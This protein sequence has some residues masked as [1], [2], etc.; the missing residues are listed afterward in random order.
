M[1]EETPVDIQAHI[2]A[3]Q[4]QISQLQ[5]IVAAGIPSP[6]PSPKGLKVATPD[7]YSG[8]LDKAETFLRQL[9]LYMHAKPGDFTTDDSRILFALSYMK[10]GT[11]GPWADRILEQLE[12]GDSLGD[13]EGFREH[14]KEAFADP[15][16]QI[17][18]RHKMDKIR[19]GQRPVEEY[20]AE[21]RTLVPRTGFNDAAH[22]EKFEKGLNSGL[23]DKIYALPEMPTKLSEWYI[24]SQKL[25]RQW[26]QRETKKKMGTQLLAKPTPPP[27][28]NTSSAPPNIDPAAMDVDGGKWRRPKTSTVICY[29]CDRPGHIARDCPDSK[30]IRGVEEESIGDS[31]FKALERAKEAGFFEKVTGEGH[32]PVDKSL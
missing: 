24:W 27:P 8:D 21:F 10:G 1:S 29:R 20:V 7:A 2:T 12:A 32:V 6:Q 30:R 16:P 25:D 26:R 15:T 3:L 9:T 22:V 4:K 31:L 13:W 5:A 11:A 18:A 14:F 23:V 28:S 17:T 19:Q